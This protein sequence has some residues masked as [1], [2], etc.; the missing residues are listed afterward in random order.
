MPPIVAV[1]GAGAIGQYIGGLL[2]G[3]SR[4]ALQVRLLGR[5]RLVDAV[6]QHGL[7]SLDQQGRGAALAPG[8]VPVTTDPAAAFAGA[9][10]ILVTTKSRD[11]TSM[12]ELIAAHA[13]P[14]AVVVSLQNGVRNV[15]RL[16]AALPG[17][18]V[19]AGMV[20]FNVVLDRPGHARRTTDGD[21]MVSAGPPMVDGRP[22]ERW[23]TVAAAAEP[24]L[25]TVARD[26]M[27]AVQWSKLLINLN[28]AL[29]ALSGQPLVTQLAERSWRLRWSACIAEGLREARAA[30]VEPAR[31][32]GPPP[33]LFRLVLALPSPVFV[34]VVLPRFGVAP[35][36]RSSMQDDIRRG[37]PTEID[38]LQ[39]EI[40]RRARAAGRD[41]PACAAVLAEI[42]ALQAAG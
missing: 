20:P 21:V 17:R 27:D 25:R 33:A 16:R 8:E 3:A 28:N 18:D 6:A 2:A 34:R 38:D 42:E 26:D 41:A 4:P 12:A 9:A 24:L 1:A 30:G 22:L 19:R 32:L 7:R 10:L 15:E 14:D 40:V 35:D 39:G 36:A 5:Q 37:R 31:V 23:L 13:P 11:T 29:N